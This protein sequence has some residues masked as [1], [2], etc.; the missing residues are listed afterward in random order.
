MLLRLLSLLTLLALVTP[1]EAQPVPPLSEEVSVDT[2]TG[3]LFG[4]LVLPAGSPADAPVALLL[5]GSGPNDRD[6]NAPL[7]GLRSN[8][9]RLLA[10]S[11]AARG[12]GSL[13]ID[14]RGIGA[15]AAAGADESALRFEHYV[16]DAVTWLTFIRARRPGAPRF[17][18]GHSEGALIGTMAAQ[19]TEVAG[20]VLL[21]GAGRPAGTVMREQFETALP[22]PLKGPAMSALDALEQGGEVSA[23][24]QLAAV[25]RPSVL[26]YLRSWLP[27]DPAAELAR[28]RVPALVLR[29]STD[30]QVT[31][32]DAQRL[33]GARPG[34][35]F[36]EIAG[37]NHP[38]KTAPADRAMNA[39]TYGDPAL[40][41]A[42][43]LVETLTGFI[44]SP[45][46][47]R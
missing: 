30:I 17:V 18:V 24:P 3:R 47:D 37:M 19:R 13:R 31:A 14:K 4:T 22:E 34:V 20:L 44:R 33:A 21:A 46:A 12:I 41:L 43:G 36:V 2:P 5:P 7:A 38:L 39:A 45:A 35:R 40:P 27:L 28:T 25:F 9:L 32:A 15:S 1:A 10:E 16:E 29:G 11:L 26:P 23:P 6:G 42:P 8:H